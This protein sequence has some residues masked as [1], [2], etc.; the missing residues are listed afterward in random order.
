VSDTLLG[1]AASDVGRSILEVRPRSAA[2]IAPIVAEVLDTRS[3]VER[4]VEDREGRVHLVRARPFRITGNEVDGAVICWLESEAPRRAAR[5]LAGGRDRL[6]AVFEV[7][8]HP[9]L[10]LDG[11]LR[12]RAVTRRYC[13]QFMVPLGDIEG[14]S[15]SAIDA[16]WN[17]PQLEQQL[18]DVLHRRAALVDFRLEAVLAHAGRRTLSFSAFRLQADEGELPALLLVVEDR[19]ASEIDPAAP[20]GLRPA[21]RAGPG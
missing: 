5:E 19:T 4:Q 13:E 15:L 9:F 18:R 1:L 14:R 10:L 7:L 3:G 6:S 21:R 12:I 2:D 20:P 17:T 16:G 8:R 11:E